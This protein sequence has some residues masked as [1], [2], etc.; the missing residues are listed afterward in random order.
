MR[1]DA[2]NRMA[3]IESQARE[4]F[5]V[6]LCVLLYKFNTADDR[7]FVIP[8]EYLEVVITRKS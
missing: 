2:G 4:A 3:T 8:S 7:T 5:A 1:R 6:D